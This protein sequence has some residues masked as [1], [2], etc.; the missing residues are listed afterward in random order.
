MSMI[1]IS[2]NNQINLKVILKVQRDQ[3]I[4][5]GLISSNQIKRNELI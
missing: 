4:N 5:R 1:L 2:M 3:R